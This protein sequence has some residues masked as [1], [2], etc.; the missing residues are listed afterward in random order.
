MISA[1][2]IVS[3]DLID[4]ITV[5]AGLIVAMTTRINEIT[6][7]TTT[8]MTDA[9]IIVAATT[10]TGVTTARVIA[11]TTSAVTAEMIGMMIDVARMTTTAMTTTARSDPHRHHL[12]GATLMARFNQPNERSTSL[13]AVNIRSTRRPLVHTQSPSNTNRRTGCKVLLSGGPN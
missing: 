7:P 3:V 5:T 6:A 2:T 8:T 4:V 1:S 12:Q 13:S 9:M 11:V 10:T